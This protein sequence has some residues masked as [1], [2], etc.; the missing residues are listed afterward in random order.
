MVIC[1]FQVLHFQLMLSMNIILRQ[2]AHSNIT[3]PKS[4]R[5]TFCLLLS[6][7]FVL[8]VM[9]LCKIISTL[10]QT[11]IEWHMLY[12]Q[13][14][15]LRVQPTVSYMPHRIF[16]CT[17]ITQSFSPFPSRWYSYRPRFSSVIIILLKAFSYTLVPLSFTRQIY[18]EPLLFQCR[19]KRPE[20]SYFCNHGILSLNPQCVCTCMCMYICTYVCIYM[21]IYV[22]LVHNKLIKFI[23]RIFL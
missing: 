2:N 8:V 6:V 19:F 22:P 13:E 21:Y 18:P 11:C 23:G 1:L 5:H 16:M 15:E 9:D 20:N 7:L 17:L 10:A 12:R 14:A 4:V 3:N